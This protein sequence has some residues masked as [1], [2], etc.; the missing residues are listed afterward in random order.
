MGERFNGIEEVKGSTPFVSTK[1]YMAKTIEELL[2][3]FDDP[4]YTKED[5]LKEKA[6]IEKALFDKYNLKPD[7]IEAAMRE[8]KIPHDCAN[9]L[10]DRW[11]SNECFSKYFGG[12]DTQDCIPAVK[13]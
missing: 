10:V 6:E 3:E 12:E 1:E 5:Y 4:P 2:E 9:D 13:V 7:E 11:V 8:H